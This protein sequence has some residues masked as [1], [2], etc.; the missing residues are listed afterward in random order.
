MFKTVFK[1]QKEVQDFIRR[2]EETTCISC[3]SDE[4]EPGK[5]ADMRAGK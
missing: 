3:M 4:D 2:V 1:I 5:L